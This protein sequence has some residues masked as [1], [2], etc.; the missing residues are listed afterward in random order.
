VVAVYR[1][2]E[3]VYEPP[4]CGPVTDGD[5]AVLDVPLPLDEMGFLDLLNI[6]ERYTIGCSSMIMHL[7]IDV[8]ATSH[9]TP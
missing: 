8:K 7:C 9:R 6:H 5:A 3:A 2:P 4:A 1:R